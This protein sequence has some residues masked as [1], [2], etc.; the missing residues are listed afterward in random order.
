MVPVFTVVLSFRKSPNEA[1]FKPPNGKTL[2][3]FKRMT[4]LWCV[5]SVWLSLHMQIQAS[6]PCLRKKNSYVVWSHIN[7]VVISILQTK[8]RFPQMLVMDSK[9]FLH[10]IKILFMIYICDM[11]F[12]Q[13]NIYKRSNCSGKMAKKNYF[14]NFNI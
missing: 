6:A 8:W 1:F 3:N 11:I 10:S 2:Q 12:I 5:I 4:G 9:K 14:L 7:S 13:I